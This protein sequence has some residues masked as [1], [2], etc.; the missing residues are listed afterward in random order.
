MIEAIKIDKRAIIYKYCDKG[1]F[2]IINNNKTN[3][4]NRIRIEIDLEGEY[5]IYQFQ[6]FEFDAGIYLH[7]AFIFASIM[8]CTLILSSC[9]H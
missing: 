6:Y 3:I 9:S 7:I 4:S 8:H 5:N 1:S 2:N